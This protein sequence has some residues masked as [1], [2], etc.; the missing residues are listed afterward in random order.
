MKRLFKII[1][2]GSLYNEMLNIRGNAILWNMDTTTL[3]FQDERN[4]L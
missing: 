3:N 1:K 4:I 2:H